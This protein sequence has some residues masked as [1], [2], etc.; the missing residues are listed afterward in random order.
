[1]IP[2]QFV[3]YNSLPFIEKRASAGRR[4]RVWRSPP[5]NPV[6]GRF[7][8]AEV[9]VVHRRKIVVYQRICVYH[10]YRGG[11]RDNSFRIASEQFVRE[12]S[13]DG[14]QAFPSR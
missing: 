5:E 12:H 11:D 8:A 10:F 13:K 3:F 7:S 4:L 9:V 6:T 2:L 1:M 14:P